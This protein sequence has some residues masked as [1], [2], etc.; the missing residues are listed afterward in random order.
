MRRRRRLVP[1][2]KADLVLVDLENSWMM[3]ARDPLRSVI[4]HAADRAVRDVYVDGHLVVAN[5]RVLTLDRAGALERLT[6]AQRRMEATVTRRDPLHRRS[7]DIA[8]L[9]LPTMGPDD[10]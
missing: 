10:S 8:P 4:F 3:P 5:G 9:S 1:G 7:G 2:A 6:E